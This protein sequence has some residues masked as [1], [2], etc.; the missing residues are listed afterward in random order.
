[1]TL[2]ILWSVVGLIVFLSFLLFVTWFYLHSGIK[3]PDGFARITGPCG[4]TMEISYMCKSGYVEDID[5]WSSG[6]SISKMCVLTAGALARGKPVSELHKINRD[7]IMEK[8]G[9][10]PDT[11]L[12]CAILA[13]KTLQAAVQ[14]QLE[15]PKTWKSNQVVN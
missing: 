5:C 8:T 15:N 6:C 7:A 14:N 3:N 4:D 12:H 13:E 10:L 9:P 11:H 2:S 1:M